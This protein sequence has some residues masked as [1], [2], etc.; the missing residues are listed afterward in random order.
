MKT[1]WHCYSNR[2][3]DEWNKIEDPPQNKPTHVWAP[4]FDKEGKNI[5]WGK[6]ASSTNG[7]DLIGCLH[8][9][10]CK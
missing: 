6:E 4:E 5:Q 1:A 3:I 7:T 9:E 10:K 8:V 2:Q